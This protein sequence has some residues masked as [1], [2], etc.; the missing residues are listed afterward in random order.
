MFIFET[1]VYLS[2]SLPP[3]IITPASYTIRED[4]T[5]YRFIFVYKALPPFHDNYRI[6]TKKLLSVG[7]GLA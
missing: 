3:A 5:K 4:C 2:V 1:K 7:G 6:A